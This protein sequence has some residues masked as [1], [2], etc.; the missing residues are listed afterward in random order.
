MCQGEVFLYTKE[1]IPTLESKSYIFLYTR[2]D[3]DALTSQSQTPR[4]FYTK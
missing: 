3:L 2:D 4:L 1:Y